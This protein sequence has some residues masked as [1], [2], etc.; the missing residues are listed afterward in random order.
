MKI[1][2]PLL[3]LASALKLSAATALIDFGPSATYG[4]L[5]AGKGPTTSPANW[6]NFTELT[7]TSTL[8]LVDTSGVPFGGI[9]ADGAFNAL[10]EAATP[11]SSPYPTTA[12]GDAFFQNTTRT[13]TLSG[14]NNSLTY[15][16]VIYGYINR[17]EARQT[18]VLINGVTKSYQ[19]G[20]FGGSGANGS[21]VTF[22]GIAP[23]AGNITI[24]LSGVGTT[25]YIFSVMEITS[26]P[27]PSVAFLGAAATA[28][29]VIGRRRC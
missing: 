18:N 2:L 12:S 9:T 28:F 6:N 29:L 1:R 26:V 15:N 21:S 13:L 19:P 17:T 4:G 23:T 10:N 20:N 5:V 27:E 24:G 16:I 8:S 11:A 7:G 25:N 22:T 14:L 3:L